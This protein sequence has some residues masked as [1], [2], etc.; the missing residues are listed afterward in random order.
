MYTYRNMTDVD[1]KMIHATFLDAFSNY[2][3]A[4]DIPLEKLQ[5]M[6]ITRSFD[7]KYS[8]GCFNNDELVG[9]SLSGYRVINGS[10]YCYDTATG[11]KQAYQHK[12]IGKALI[13]HLIAMLKKEGIQ[14]F[15]LEVLENNEAAQKIYKNSGF[16]ITR[17]LNCYKALKKFDVPISDTYNFS[18][19]ANILTTIDEIA[20]N[21]YKPSWQ[22]SLESY[23]NCVKNYDVISLTI[24]GEMIGYLIVYKSSNNIL[25]LGIREDKRNKGF[26]EI[27]L[28][29]MQRLS[30]LDECSLLNVEDGS[31]IDYKLKEIGFEKNVSQYEMQVNI[32]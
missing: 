6:M 9:F 1:I 5:E 21:S 3:V 11:I 19:D 27:L 30:A 15:L 20:F 8:L 4:F 29:E 12:H 18:Y 16:E 22:N 28:S 26:E 10:R 32:Q 23:K 14:Y 24:Q 13:T 2:E 7:A 31:Y 17:K 25:Q